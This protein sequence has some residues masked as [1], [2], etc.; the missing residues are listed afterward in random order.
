MG[1][2]IGVRGIVIEYVGGEVHGREI[3]VVQVG[4]LAQVTNG[5]GCQRQQSIGPPG[6]KSVSHIGVV[7]EHVDASDD[8]CAEIGRNLEADL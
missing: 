4:L 2:R 6:T 7:Q 8:D 5:K 1:I 3:R